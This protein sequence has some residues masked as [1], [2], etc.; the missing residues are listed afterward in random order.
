MPNFRGKNP[1]KIDASGV[2]FD[3]RS[4]VN[5]LC[6]VKEKI[7]IFGTLFGTAH[8]LTAFDPLLN[9]LQRRNEPITT[10]LP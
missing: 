2:G 3:Y 1:G 6:A 4:P 10:P 5:I 8:T 9:R 7:D